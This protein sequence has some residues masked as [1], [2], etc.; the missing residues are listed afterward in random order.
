MMRKRFSPYAKDF[1]EERPLDKQGKASDEQKIVNAIL[2][3]L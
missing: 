3:T 1:V 2:L